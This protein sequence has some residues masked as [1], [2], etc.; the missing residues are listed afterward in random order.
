MGIAKLLSRLSNCN[1]R[2]DEKCK[3]P[4]FFSIECRGIDPVL[5]NL[6]EVSQFVSEIVYDDKYGWNL[7][8]STYRTELCQNLNLSY[9]KATL[10]TPGMCAVVQICLWQSWQ[11]ESMISSSKAK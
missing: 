2:S 3:R 1:I 11:A 8:K 7:E 5:T 6:T 9:S 10:Q 4:N